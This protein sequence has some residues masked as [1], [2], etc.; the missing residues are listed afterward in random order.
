MIGLVLGLT[1]ATAVFV[2]A[3]S[4]QS[5]PASKPEVPSPHFEVIGTVASV[6]DGDTISVSIIEVDESIEGVTTGIKTVRFSGGIDAPE[7]WT[8]PP[9]E[10]SYEATEFIENLI[11]HGTGVYL[12][13]DD[14]STTPYNDTYGRLLAVIYVEIDDLWVNVNA[15]LL[16]WGQEE[17]PDIN[18]LRFISY[19]SEFDPYEWLEENYPYVRG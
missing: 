17:Y 7:T 15:E 5:E 8:N 6:A 11:P 16:R 1:I 9:E 4:Y 2:F 19:S 12:D 13:L 3:L 18:W 14:L 10:G